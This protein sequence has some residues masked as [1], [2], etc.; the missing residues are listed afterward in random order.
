MFQSFLRLADQPD[1]RASDVYEDMNERPATSV[2][3]AM[4]GEQADRL[5]ALFDTH[6]DRLYRLARRLTQGGSD[7]V[8]LVQETFL[9]AARS[10]ESIP[11]GF[12]NEEAWLV[13]VLVNVRRD[14]WRRE[15]VRKRHALNLSHT[16]VHNHDDPERAVLIRATIWRALDYLP[17]RR[18]TVVVMYELE[19]LSMTSIA[20]VLGISTITVRW[21]LARGRRELAR[22]LRFELGDTNEQHQHALA[23]R[24]PAPSRRPTL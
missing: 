22:R 4:S 6:S 23:G 17:P 10:L 20:S 9:K 5:A 11:H 24:R 2:P 8:D 3:Q 18:R 19:G 13:R 21:H 16:A 1:L 7:A 15:A 12:K 14:Q